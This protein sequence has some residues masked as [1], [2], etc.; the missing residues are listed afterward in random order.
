MIWASALFGIFVG[1]LA[2]CGWLQAQY[3]LERAIA[4]EDRAAKLAKQ[5]EFLVNREQFKARPSPPP[6]PPTKTLRY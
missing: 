6:M 3:N 4:A 2:Y 5:L 1:F